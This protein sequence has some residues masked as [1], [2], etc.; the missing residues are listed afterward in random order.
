MRIISFINKRGKYDTYWADTSSNGLVNSFMRTGTANV[1]Q[2]ME[3]LLLG[4]S[5]TVTIDEQ[6]V[7]NQLDESANAVWSI[8]MAL[9]YLKVLEKE[10]LRPDR[11]D[12]PRY[13]LTLLIAEGF[14]PERIRKYGFAF[15]GKTCLIG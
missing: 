9:G 6:I 3:E 12:D 2:I 15:V 13:K 5:F 11:M 14:A 4:K 7:F 10:E 1:K 8:L